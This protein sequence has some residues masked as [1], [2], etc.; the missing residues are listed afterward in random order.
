MKKSTNLFLY[1][2]CAI[3]I[4]VVF[5]ALACFIKPSIAADKQ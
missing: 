5:T 1:R 2:I 3:A 4:M